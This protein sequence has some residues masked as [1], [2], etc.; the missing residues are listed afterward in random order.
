MPCRDCNC[1]CCYMGVSS[2][3][4]CSESCAMKHKS[5]LD[6]PQIR[7]FVQRDIRNK[8]WLACR[9]PSSW[10]QLELTGKPGSLGR[11][12]PSTLMAGEKGRFFRMHILNRG[13]MTRRKTLKVNGFNLAQRNPIP[14]DFSMNLLF[15]QSTAFAFT[16]YKVGLAV[17]S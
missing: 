5:V 1:N 12:H 8:L 4:D 13:H 6:M 14:P 16:K 17:P 7:R 10:L 2:C 15:I 9:P 3:S 11:P